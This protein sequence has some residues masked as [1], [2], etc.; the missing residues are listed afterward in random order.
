M[1]RLVRLL[2]ALVSLA[3]SCVA[4]SYALALSSAAGQGAW[5]LFPA[6]AFKIVCRRDP[7]GCPP[8]L[9]LTAAKH[10]PLGATALADQLM[11]EGPGEQR[12]D[13]A[14]LVLRQ[15]TRSEL[16][17]VILA[18]EAL[19]AGDRAAFLQLYLPLFATDRRQSAAYADV[20]AA[21]SEDPELYALVEIHV[22]EERPGWGG[23]YLGALAGRAGL[24]L[25]EMIDLYAEFPKAQPGLLAQMTKTGNWRGAY[26]AFHEFLSSGAL[27][28]EAGMPALS[29]PYNPDLLQLEAPSPFNWRVHGQGAEW[30]GKGGVYAYFQGR[31]PET[32]LTQ[33]LPLAPGAWRISATMSGEVSETGGHFRWQLSCAASGKRFA[34][35]EVRGL[36]SSPAE[37]AFEFDHPAG[38]CDFAT[39]SL[40]GVPG[41]FPQPARLEVTQVRLAPNI[42]GQGVPE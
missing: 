25:G 35:F 1:S 14:A 37:Q 28:R 33:S 39:L 17:R 9:A 38:V 36:T 2:A 29:V 31:R 34:A 6:Q 21:L 12:A 27:T 5:S 4:A 7:E 22:R 16:A 32:F 41:T 20:L 40:I 11:A 15:D 10:A 26:L 18:E 8:D 3:G 24:P 42:P 23:Q 13:L 19:S 30:L